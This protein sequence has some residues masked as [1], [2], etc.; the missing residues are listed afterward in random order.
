M[1]RKWTVGFA[2]L[3]LACTASISSAAPELPEPELPE[4]E[5]P[6]PELPDGVTADMVEEGRQIF[7]SV[8][9]CTACH[10]DGTGTPLA[11]DLTDEEWINIDGSYDAIIGLVNT[12]VPEPIEA[13]LPMLPKGG[14]G[15]NDDQ[16]RSVAAYVWSLSRGG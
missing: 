14:S 11:P 12:G 6:K 7:S 4:P 16:I 1:N 13:P 8:G 10:G 2:L 9:Q 5:L 3:T 15:I